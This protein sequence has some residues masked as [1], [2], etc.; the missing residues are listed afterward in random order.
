MVAR[1]PSV[2]ATVSPIEIRPT[3]DVVV[4]FVPLWLPVKV[5]PML[6]VTVSSVGSAALSAVWIVVAAAV[7]LAAPERE[8]PEHQGLRPRPE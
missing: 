1:K 8:Q 5:S 6:A 3:V 2:P 4:R 7:K